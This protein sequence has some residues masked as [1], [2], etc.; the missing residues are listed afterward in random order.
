MHN[1][2]NILETQSTVCYVS[3][4]PVILSFL[5]SSEEMPEAKQT[6]QMRTT[7]LNILH[8]SFCFF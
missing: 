1:D 7:I 2:V 4:R 3:R 6:L 8:L 5:V